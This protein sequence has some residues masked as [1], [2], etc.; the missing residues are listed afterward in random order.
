MHRNIYINSKLKYKQLGG[1]DEFDLL[2]QVQASL[3]T[4]INEKLRQDKIDHESTNKSIGVCGSALRPWVIY[5][6]VNNILHTDKNFWFA[7]NYATRLIV[8]GNVDI[9]DKRHKHAIIL[10][11]CK[12]KSIVEL[13]NIVKK[14]EISKS[15]QILGQYVKNQIRDITSEMMGNNPSFKSIAEYRSAKQIIS[16]LQLYMHNYLPVKYQFKSIIHPVLTDILR[17]NIMKNLEKNFLDVLF[18]GIYNICKP[19]EH[20][21]DKY[22]SEKEHMSIEHTKLLLMGGGKKTLKNM[23]DNSHLVK[24]ITD[25]DIDVSNMQNL[26][27]DD[28]RETYIKKCKLM[29]MP[30]SMKLN[31]MEDEISFMIEPI[32]EDIFATGHTSSHN[33]MISLIDR[34]LTLFADYEKDI[35]IMLLENV[36]ET[37]AHINKTIADFVKLV[38]AQLNLSNM[39]NIDT[40]EKIYENKYVPHIEKINHLADIAKN[41]RIENIK[42]ERTRLFALYKSLNLEIPIKKIILIKQEYSLS[43]HEKNGLKI[44]KRIQNLFYLMGNNPKNDYVYID[45]CPTEEQCLKENKM[46]IIYP[47]KSEEIDLT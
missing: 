19:F 18:F 7:V 42:S 38:E 33:P 3:L 22:I 32:Y 44:A 36:S 45:N 21:F 47:E 12:S 40:N 5:G 4:E 20:V 23:F 16:W 13:S 34:Y 26:Y 1:G 6:N 27:I 9:D 41:K 29:M 8:W 10:G 14:W 25:D 2:E 39:Y 11:A 46:C 37:N 31:R 24:D 15:Y 30:S 17:M 28:F 43:S 35:N